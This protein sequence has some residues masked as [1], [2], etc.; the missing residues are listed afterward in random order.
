MN[1]TGD[2]NSDKKKKKGEKLKSQFNSPHSRSF[3]FEHHDKEAGG[4]AIACATGRSTAALGL[5]IDTPSPLPRKRD[6]KIE[7]IGI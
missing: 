7:N 4:S 5:A 6:G 2:L 3:T 1:P